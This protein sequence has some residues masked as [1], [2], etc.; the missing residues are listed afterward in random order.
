MSDAEVTRAEEL[1]AAERDGMQYGAAAVGIVLCVL[2]ALGCAI[3][4]IAGL[5][6]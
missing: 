1:R 3:T 6:S 2:I 4:M 5:L